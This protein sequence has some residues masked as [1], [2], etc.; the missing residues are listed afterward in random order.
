MAI[1]EP[2]FQQL[3]EKIDDGGIRSPKYPSTVTKV[4]C[5]T[6]VG[7]EVHLHGNMQVY[8]EAGQEVKKGDILM[9]VEG[10]KMEV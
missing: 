10:M 9:T 1:P 5:T 6:S 7:V 8:V 3:K 4:N 2:S